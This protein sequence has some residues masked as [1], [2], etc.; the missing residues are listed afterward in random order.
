MKVIKYL[1]P[2]YFLS[3]ALVHLGNWCYKASEWIQGDDPNG[4]WTVLTDEE[5][6]KKMAE[7]IEK[8]KRK[9]K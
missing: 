1:M 8:A 3:H 4:P 6:E 5:F 7:E 9:G 2:S